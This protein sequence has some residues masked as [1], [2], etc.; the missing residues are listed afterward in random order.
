MT[1]GLSFLPLQKVSEAESCAVSG[2]SFVMV[3]VKPE[4][5]LAVH[6][7]PGWCA[8]PRLCK[9]GPEMARFGQDQQQPVT[10]LSA[11]AQAELVSTFA[12]TL[13]PRLRTAD[14]QALAQ[15][16]R[17]FRCL[18]SQVTHRC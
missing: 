8:S 3:S 16:S 18:L 7:C 5:A 6:N 12:T 10:C 1:A 4:A 13:V 15:T 9:R 17:S 14:L 11:E 2:M